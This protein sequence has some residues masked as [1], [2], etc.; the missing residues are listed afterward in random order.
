MIP[1]FPRFPKVSGVSEV[2]DL[3]ED[4]EGGSFGI[5]YDKRTPPPVAIKKTLFNKVMPSHGKKHTLLEN[6][7]CSPL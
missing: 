7:H 5:R 3:S 2:S 6:W 4:S 1:R